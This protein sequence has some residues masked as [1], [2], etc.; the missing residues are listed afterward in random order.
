MKSCAQDWDRWS[1]NLARI[2][3]PAGALSLDA[4]AEEWVVGRSLRRMVQ[5]QEQDWWALGSAALLQS[6]SGPRRPQIEDQHLRSSAR[7]RCA[8]DSLTQV[9]LELGLNHF[10]AGI[11][12]LR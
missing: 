9:M 2:D 7:S 5:H 1:Q 10:V 12:R 3:Y 4:D 11:V 8:C 6:S